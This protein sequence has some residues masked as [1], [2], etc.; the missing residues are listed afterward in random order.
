MPTRIDDPGLPSGGQLEWAFGCQRRSDPDQ[1]ASEALAYGE[2]RR[3]LWRFA[4]EAK[5]PLDLA[6]AFVV[7][8]FGDVR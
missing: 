4:L 3:R 6:L 5:P 7:H 8:E 2:A 1:S